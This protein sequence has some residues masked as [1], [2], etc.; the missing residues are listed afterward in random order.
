MGNSEMCECREYSRI[1]T[2]MQGL[3]GLGAHGFRLPGTGSVATQPAGDLVAPRYGKTRQKGTQ[4]RWIA[5]A[6]NDF[7][8]SGQHVGVCVLV[9]LSNEKH[10]GY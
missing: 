10:K 4:G 5:T 8:W 9:F 2:G 7:R 6:R 3:T 1:S